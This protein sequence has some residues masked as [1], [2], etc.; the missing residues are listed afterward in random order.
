ML[1]H[2]IPST[3]SSLPDS[4]SKFPDSQAMFFLLDHLEGIRRGSTSQ[5]LDTWLLTTDLPGGLGPPLLPSRPAPLLQPESAVLTISTDPSS[6]ISW[7]PP[8]L[9]LGRGWNPK[10]RILRF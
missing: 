4:S 3:W 8:N 5:E 7:F 6:E 9:P 2:T 10:P 1:I